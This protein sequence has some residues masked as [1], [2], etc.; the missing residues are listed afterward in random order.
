VASLDD[1]RGV[2][3]AGVNA[4]GMVATIVGVPL[5]VARRLARGR[6]GMVLPTAVAIGAGLTVAT[7]RTGW[8]LVKLWLG[9]DQG[10]GELDARSA[11][12]S[13]R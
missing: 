13:E 5:L 7:R 2:M 4:L 11:Q 10:S 8:S 12:D 3:V 1:V 6:R 9:I